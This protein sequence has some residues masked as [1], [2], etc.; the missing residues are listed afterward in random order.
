[1]HN[2]HSPLSPLSRTQFKLILMIS[3][4]S[5]LISSFIGSSIGEIIFI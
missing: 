2:V 3:L 4:S 1:L 5:A